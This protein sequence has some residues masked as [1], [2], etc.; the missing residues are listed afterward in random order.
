MR[1]SADAYEAE[2]GPRSRM[3]E[4]GLVLMHRESLM[5]RFD[6]TCGPLIA[7]PCISKGHNP[8]AL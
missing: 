1:G 7:P 2:Q 4:F 3:T 6:V 8:P 5:Q